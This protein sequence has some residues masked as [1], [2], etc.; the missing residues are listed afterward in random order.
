MNITI[1]RN[2]ENYGPYSLDQAKE[3]LGNGTLS[4]SDL[5]L[6]EGCSEWRSLSSVLQTLSIKPLA[7]VVPP[8]PAPPP[9][10]APTPNVAQV[11]KTFPV[12]PT[13]SRWSLIGAIATVVALVIVG[14]PFIIGVFGG[15]EITEVK[16]GTLNFDTTVKIGSALDGYSYF[17]NVTWK[18]FKTPQGRT[19]VEATALVNIEAY[20]NASMDDYGNKLPPECVDAALKYDKSLQLMYTAQFQLSQTDSSITVGYSGYTIKSHRADT[21]EPSEVEERDDEDYK[22]LKAIIANQPEKQVANLLFD[23][24]QIKP[25]PPAP[26]QTSNPSTLNSQ[27]S[28]SNQ[29]AMVATPP[30][31]PANLAKTKKQIDQLNSEL[32]ELDKEQKHEVELAVNK[33]DAQLVEAKADVVTLQEKITEQTKAIADF[34]QK[35]DPKKEEMDRLSTERATL[36]NSFDDKLH[37]LNESGTNLFKDRINTFHSAAQLINTAIVSGSVATDLVTETGLYAEETDYASYQRYRGDYDNIFFNDTEPC[38]A[39]PIPIVGTI[40]TSHNGKLAVVVAVKYYGM[41]KSATSMIFKRFPSEVTDPKVRQDFVSLY[42]KHL[43]NR[44]MADGV[45]KDIEAATEQQRLALQKW[46]Y[47]NGKKLEEAQSNEANIP[48]QIGKMEFEVTISNSALKDKL[49]LI[50]TPREQ[51]LSQINAQLSS[52]FDERRQTIREKLAQLQ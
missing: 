47:L 14:I 29:S 44:E 12:K 18:S 11:G 10:Q 41:D 27:A 40:V 7:P 46:D 26:S 9:L 20:K 22:M 39:N 32:A 35:N 28:S 17:N 15:D 1:H 33:L 36:S 3:Y 48:A 25:K 21:G 43:K 6:Y 49:A 52:Q 45:Q 5:A 16:E 8:P 38:Y 13:K 30:V 42:G 19:V 37:A 24:S 2:G 50:N 4:E 23:I 51:Q 31:S 34:K